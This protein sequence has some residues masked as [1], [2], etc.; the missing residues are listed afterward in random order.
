MTSSG[1]GAGKRSATKTSE[2]SSFVKS[3]KLQHWGDRRSQLLLHPAQIPAYLRPSSFSMSLERDDVNSESCVFAVPGHLMKPDQSIQSVDDVDR[4]LR[5][6]QYWGLSHYVS[7]ELCE[8]VFTSMS[9]NDLHAAVEPYLVALGDL[10]YVLEARMAVGSSRMEV[11]LRSGLANLVQCLL[12]LG[13]PLP[14]EAYRL[15]AANRLDDS[16]CLQLV[17]TE[18]SKMDPA[19]AAA[20]VEAGNIECLSYAIA[21]GCNLGLELT[22]VCA[23]HGQLD[24]LRHLRQRA[25]P[26]SAEVCADAA[27]G[28]HLDCLRYAHEHGCMWDEA[29][30]SAAAGNGHLVCLQYAHEHG[31]AWS[32]RVCSRAAWSGSLD[33]L[34][35]AHFHGCP[36]TPEVMEAA[37]AANSLECMEFAHAQGCP[38]DSGASLAAVAAGS[39]GC[40][41]FAHQQGCPWDEQTMAIAAKYGQLDCMRFAHENGCAW[42][43]DTVQ[44]A[45]EYSRLSCAQYALEHGCSWTNGAW[46]GELE[47]GHRACAACAARRGGATAAAVAAAAAAS[48]GGFH[49]PLLP[50]GEQTFWRQE[51][52]WSPPGST[53]GPDD[54]PARGTAGRGGA[55]R[56]AMLKKDVVVGDAPAPRLSDDARVPAEREREQ[57]GGVDIGS[58]AWGRSLQEAAQR[59]VQSSTE[60]LCSCV[61]RH[62]LQNPSLWQKVDGCM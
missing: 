29:T 52:L 46:G 1:S 39:L 35:Y 15:A 53:G 58:D 23:R 7:Y 48:G 32:S 36:W 21:H 56:A 27:A 3:R 51:Q 49:L 61:A 42:G 37:A 31:C 13:Y 54:A 59:F 40:L 25:C 57:G 12:Q 10:H 6:V 11:A 18:R 5:T 4:Y 24:C 9:T 55:W 14:P 33:C 41:Q 45:S 16:T 8:F 47:E 28:G 38:W 43:F 34:Q 22:R 50:G 20:A 44:T 60:L 62:L 19:T 2:D 17:H 30:C 26:W